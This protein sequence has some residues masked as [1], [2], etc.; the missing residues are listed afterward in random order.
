MK[1]RRV[2]GRMEGWEVQTD[3]SLHCENQIQIQ[4]RP[5]D[6]RSLNTHRVK[7]C[8]QQVLARTP[9]VSTQEFLLSSSS[10]SSSSSFLYCVCSCLQSSVICIRR[11]CFAELMCGR[12]QKWTSSKAA[13]KNTTPLPK[14]RFFVFV[15]GLSCLIVA[16]ATGGHHLTISTIRVIMTCLHGRPVWPFFRLQGVSILALWSLSLTESCSYPHIMVGKSLRVWK[17]DEHFLKLTMH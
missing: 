14:A 3:E 15:C 5:K 8:P 6:V 1:R 7:I 17:R 2:D 9:A 4:N 11:P 16:A 10:S 13:H 12:Q